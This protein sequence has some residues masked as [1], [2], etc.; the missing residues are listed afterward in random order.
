MNNSADRKL[1]ELAAA[2]KRKSPPPMAG[3][4]RIP[5]QNLD[6]ER[7]VLGSLLL[8][9]DAIDDIAW[10]KVEHFYSNPHQ[11]IYKA[12]QGLRDRKVGG[13]DPVT[14]VDALQVSGELEDAGGAAYIMEVLE[15]VPHA[16]HVRYYAKIVRLKH[17]QRSLIYAAT[18]ILAKSYE[19]YTEPELDEMISEAEQA[20]LE[21]RE[22]EETG[23]GGDVKDVVLESLAE[24]EAKINGKGAGLKTGYTDLD[25][26]VGGLQSSEL[27]ILA[28]R[29]SMGKTAFVCNV[30]E[31]IAEQGK[32]VLLF[33]LEQSR[34]ELVNR[35]LSSK[36][37]VNGKSIRTGEVTEDD[38]QKI[39]NASTQISRLPIII[40][41]KPEVT[42]SYMAA[43]ARRIHRK[44][45]L[46]ILII[47]YLQL[48]SAD[49]KRQP[50]QEQIATISRKL[51][52]LNKELDVP[53]IALAQLNRDVEKRTA[54]RPM[55][56]DL[57]ESG[58][59]EQDADIVMMLHRPIVYDSDFKD[60]G[61]AEMVITKHRNGT[62]GVVNLTWRKEVMRFENHAAP[63][64]EVGFRF[65]G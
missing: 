31:N 52:Y 4:V 33:S 20:V 32:T 41:D 61:L 22:V 65:L 57:R 23:D 25:F 12:I 55:L 28:A 18:D 27:V 29:P 59:I 11:A 35:L 36:S 49:D 53:I 3:E 48:I 58:S 7:S 47:D 30:A 45:P 63:L 50:R 24:L 21:V 15:A 16:A 54:K 1:D 62:T 46:G 34:V 60:E 19:L 5:P 43:V 44:T 39:M 26:Q 38:R 64:P 40:K 56:S 42:M 37:G 6:A 14:L 10:L 13:I 9:N 51:K 2:E 8:L 17:R